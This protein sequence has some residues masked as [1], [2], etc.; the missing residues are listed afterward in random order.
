MTYMSMLAVHVCWLSL[1]RCPPY[2]SSHPSP[3]PIRHYS[4]S[5]KQW[6]SY[7]RCH[8]NYYW[9]VAISKY[10][11]LYTWIGVLQDWANNETKSLNSHTFWIII[12]VIIIKNHSHNIHFTFIK[13]IFKKLCSHRTCV[14]LIYTEM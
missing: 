2:I 10:N 5:S 12:I 4:H 3:V 6:S 11:L 7:C 14:R 1:T 13:L 9:S 8:I